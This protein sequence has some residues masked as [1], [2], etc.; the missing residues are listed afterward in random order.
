LDLG[1]EDGILFGLIELKKCDAINKINLS[2]NRTI[3]ADGIGNLL[4]ARDSKR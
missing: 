2:L 1:E 4:V 3:D